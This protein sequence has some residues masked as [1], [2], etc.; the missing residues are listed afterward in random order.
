MPM[1]PNEFQSRV[2]K[3]FKN[4]TEEEFLSNLRKSS[5]YLFS[6]ESEEQEKDSSISD[7]ESCLMQDKKSAI[8]EAVHDTAKGLHEAGV[9]DQITFREFDYV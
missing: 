5:P 1:D 7:S 3:H 8:L 9:M 2:T 4:V 6:K